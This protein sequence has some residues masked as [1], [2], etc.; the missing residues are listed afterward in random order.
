MKE[1]CVW[2]HNTDFDHFCYESSCGAKYG[3]MGKYMDEDYEFC[4]CCGKTI[5]QKQPV[6]EVE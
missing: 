4:P 6:K 1:K 3:L 5:E 2:K